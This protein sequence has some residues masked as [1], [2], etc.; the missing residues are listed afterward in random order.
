[1]GALSVGNVKK[2]DRNIQ[3]YQARIDHL[4]DL[5]GLKA[6]GIFEIMMDERD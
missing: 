1:M 5:L 2:G 3:W 6:K 4:R